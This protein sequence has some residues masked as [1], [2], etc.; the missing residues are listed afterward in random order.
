MQPPS[1]VSDYLERLTRA[2][3]FDAPLA[4]RVR[5][6]AEDHLLEALA[7]SPEGE[8]PEAQRRALERFGDPRAI[9]SQYA[10]QSL[11]RQTRRAGAIVIL[12]TAGVY[13]AMKGRASWYGLMQW[14]MSADLQAIAPVVIRFD[15][16][17]FILACALGIVGWAYIS[18]RRVAPSFHPGCR[19]QLR[20]GRLLC[21][22][23]AAPLATSVVADVILTV[24]RLADAAVSPAALVPLL[25]QAIEVALV[26]V[27]VMRVRRIIRHADL[28]AA[29]TSP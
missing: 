25:T 17:A 9:A 13:L 16:Y 26:G 6:E 24:L 2:L 27:L 1:L 15:F 20:R 28:A 14:G 4:H 22:A 7:G 11:L 19:A 21:A 12:A 23:A 10:A 29:L 8:S 18:S 3:S 5:R